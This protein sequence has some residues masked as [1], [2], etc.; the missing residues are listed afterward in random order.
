MKLNLLA[1]ALLFALNT[2]AQSTNIDSI[3][4]N[5]LYRNFR[6]YKPAVYTGFTAR[7][8][9]INM[10]GYTS[11]AADQQMYSNFMPIA[12]TANFLMVCPNGTS[13]NGSQ[14]W[15]AGIGNTGANDIQ[16]ISDLITHLSLNYNI[17]LNRVYATGMSNGGFMSQTL[18]CALNNKI[19]AVASVTGSMFTSQYTTCAPNRPVPVM[20]ISGT[21][22]NTVPY[23]GTT[24]TLSI[25]SLVNYWVTNNNCTTTPVVTAIPNTNTTDGCTAERS[26]YTNGNAGSTVELYKI[27]GGGHTW[28]GA[29]IT[30]GVTNQDMSASKEIWR[31]FRKYKLSQFT[32]THAL[33]N[34]NSVRLYPNP[35]TNNI[36]IEGV[37]ATTLLKITDV[38]GKQIITTPY[39]NIDISTLSTGIY[40]IEVVGTNQRL[41]LIKE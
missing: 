20:Q 39:Q 3:V 8:L 2:Q 18:A 21:A 40:T 4:S 17:D 15:N 32:A 29:P 7:P 13:S 6:L 27:I 22:D 41:K 25:T 28:P 31:F 36:V 9:I 16:F 11:N 24:N 35:A 5:G 12:D 14:Y 34:V 1:A 26:V 23:A 38:L 37:S 10:H 19:A 33:N 30:I